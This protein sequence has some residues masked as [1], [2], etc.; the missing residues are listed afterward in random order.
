MDMFGSNNA[1]TSNERGKVGGE[2]SK[3]AKR[4]DQMNDVLKWDEEDQ[5][6]DKRLR[7]SEIIQKTQINVTSNN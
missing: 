6:K 1:A 4:A 3:S 2:R 5:V 7:Q